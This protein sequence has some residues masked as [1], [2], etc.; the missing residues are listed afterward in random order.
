MIPGGSQ[1]NSD[2]VVLYE[3]RDGSLWAG[4]YGRRAVAA[5]KNGQQR[6]FTAADGLSSNQIRSLVE[7]ADGTLWIGTFGGGLNSMRDGRF[8]HVTTQRRLVERQRLACGGRRTRFPL[9]EHHARNLPG[10]E[11]G[12]LGFCARQDSFDQRGELRRGRRAAQRPVRTRLPHQPRRHA[13]QRR[14]P[15]VSNQP[16][17]GGARSERSVASRGRAACSSAGSH[18]GWTSQWR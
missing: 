15:V 5:A 1:L 6:L 2:A 18:G 16:R 10:A 8:F 14:T 4:T 17:S 12:D 13:N 11:A 9:A 3:T 7:D